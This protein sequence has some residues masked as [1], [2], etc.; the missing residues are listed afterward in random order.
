[1]KTKSMI[2]LTTALCGFAFAPSA[3]AQPAGDAFADPK[4]PVAPAIPVAPEQAIVILVLSDGRVTMD[5]QTIDLVGLDR[6]LATIAR[7]TPNQRLRLLAD[8]NLPYDRMIAVVDICRKAGIS[9]IAMEHIPTGN[10]RKDAFAGPKVT[11]APKALLKPDIQFRVL[12]NGK[13][14][15]DGKMITLAELEGRLLEI[16]K[17]VSPP[18]VRLIGDGTTSDAQM[19]EVR[20]VLR[21]T[22]SE[23]VALAKIGTSD[24]LIRYEVFSIDPAKASAM[25]REKPTDGKF[26]ADLVALLEKGEAAQESL[27]V[28]RCRSGQKATA[29]SKNLEIY[30]TEWEP[31]P[32]GSLPGAQGDNP[33]KVV[34]PL[35]AEAFETRNTGEEI[36]VEPI[37][38]ENSRIIELMLI[39]SHTSLAERTPWG[40]DTSLT[41]MPLFETQRV[42]TNANLTEG[43]PFLLSTMNPPPDS[44]VHANRAWFAF[45]TASFVD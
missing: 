19:A 27:M 11:P 34:V 40:K 26:Y 25:R 13:V 4:A 29:E 6:K 43:E 32:A 12:G 41:E 33:P 16:R 39:A 23:I 9:N 37:R 2:L 45:A 17:T 21:K 31:Q 1:M 36:E 14:M 5:G 10:P 7:D 38:G 18:H 24:M 20:E 42:T 30:P 44:K 15:V 28:V 8:T 3:T 35:L 22:G